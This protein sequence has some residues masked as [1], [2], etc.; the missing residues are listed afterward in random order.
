LK[1]EIGRTFILPLKV[2]IAGVGMAGG[3]LHLNA[4]RQVPGLEVSALCDPDLDK[5]RSVAGEKGVPYVYSSLDEALDT[6][7]ADIVS[8][9]SPPSSHFRLCR[10]AL[11][12]GCHVLVEKPIFQTLDEAGQIHDIID[13]TGSKLSAVHN[14]KYQHGL[15][16]AMKLV[17]EGAIGDILQIHA[18]RMIDGDKDRLAVDPSSWCHTLPGGRWEELIAH[19]LYKAYQ[20]MGPMRFDHLEM[21]RTHNRW[22]WLPADELEI[23]LEGGRGYISIKLSANAEN[24]DFIVVYGSKR[25]LYVDSDMAIDPLSIAGLVHSRPPLHKLLRDRLLSVLNPQTILSGRDSH[26]ALVKDFI[27]YIQGRRAEPPVDWQEAFNTLELGLQ[28][29]R[30]IQRHKSVLEDVKEGHT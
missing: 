8:V 10:L 22:P 4:Y 21:K 2:I 17:K 19:P 20:F 16:E 3:E 29:G 1:A 13:R 23:V 25:Y 11:E 30:E 15:Q 18:V 24:Y 26:A 6:Q 5:A 27:A 28:I 14:A 7:P 9:C 12:H